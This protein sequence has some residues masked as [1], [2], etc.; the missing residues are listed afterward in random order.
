MLCFCDI[1]STAGLRHVLPDVGRDQEQ[2]HGAGPAPPR[3][4][5]RARWALFGLLLFE[6]KWLWL[7][8]FT[9]A[10]GYY[11]LRVSA[12]VTRLLP[13]CVDVGMLV[14]FIISAQTQ[15]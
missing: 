15:V 3:G 6:R 10:V 4:G 2:D 7:R 11:C 1:V 8:L 5:A 14:A 12:V 13:K 9:T